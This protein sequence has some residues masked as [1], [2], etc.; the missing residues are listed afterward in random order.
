VLA[1][2]RISDSLPRTVLLK[3]GVK[4]TKL[5][6]LARQNTPEMA[7]KASKKRLTGKRSRVI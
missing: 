3:L 2:I 1:R 7:V 6:F 4:S 5:P